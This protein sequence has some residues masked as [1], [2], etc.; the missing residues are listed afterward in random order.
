MSTGSVSDDR[1]YQFACTEKA[2]RNWIAAA[3]DVRLKHD[4]TAFALFYIP[5]SR[6]FL[7]E[8]PLNIPQLGISCSKHEKNCILTEALP[9]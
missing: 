2:I 3:L 8:T 1:V 4:G 6:K 7:S 9:S 5:Y